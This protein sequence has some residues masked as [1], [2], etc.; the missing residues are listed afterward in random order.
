L[1]YDLF[2]H[3]SYMTYD[4]VNR[5][6]VMYSANHWEQTDSYDQWGNMSC[7][8][9]GTC[10]MGLTFNPANNRIATL[11]G[12]SAGISYDAAGNMLSDG[13]AAG[14][15]TYTW[16]AKGFAIPR[17]AGGDSPRRDAENRM[18]SVT[19][20]GFSTTTFA[21]NALGERVERAGP[22]IPRSPIGEYYDAFENLTMT[23]DSQYVLE[24]NFPAVGGKNFVK[25]QNNATYFLHANSL[26]STGTI[27]DQ[28]GALIESE[29]YD[30]WGQRWVTYNTI[31][32]ERFAG[33]PK[34]RDFES[35]LDP[36]P[37]RMFTSNYARWL[38][39]DP[40]AGDITNP[41]SLNR[42]AYVMNNPLT[43]TDLSGMGPQAGSDF[44]PPEDGQCVTMP[45]FWVGAGFCP[46]E[47]QSCAGIAPGVSIGVV[48]LN[49][50]IFMGAP[51]GCA[52]SE[53]D[54]CVRSIFE[55][56]A[57]TLE[58]QPS[59]WGIFAN[60]LSSNF[61][62]R[63]GDSCFGQFL[64]ASLQP[65]NT[66]ATFVTSTVPKDVAAAAAVTQQ[67]GIS[68]TQFSNM[69]EQMGDAG[70]AGAAE[71][72]SDIALAATTMY[73]TSG[74]LST[75][76]VPKVA[77]ATLPLMAGSADFSLG[78]GIVAEYK[79]VRNGSCE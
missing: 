15:H 35:G 64:G 69:L 9:T 42:Y 25:Y 55:L 75:L 38:S 53:L 52:N 68:L 61:G 27:T 62:K 23:H 74:Y 50:T 41:Q 47:F 48:G 30:P 56:G 37:N 66:A 6:S 60:D 49:G 22:A 79:A 33:M 58:P 14:S 10:P 28:T 24:V 72:S 46:A 36:T 76:V 40:L 7:S 34:E 70:V 54:G 1:P 43:L 4:G 13:T 71:K 21:Y 2:P 44:C 5:L 63:L 3:T 78:V 59:W 26:G 31:Y 57:V 12:S 17:C 77:A 32:D 16:V 65:F 29:I 20:Q 73:S 19:V 51:P 45:P 11:N 67:A 18:A 8:G 39:P